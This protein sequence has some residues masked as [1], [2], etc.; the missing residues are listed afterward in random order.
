MTN[1]RQNF[2]PVL[3]KINDRKL[4]DLLMMGEQIEGS[5]LDFAY[6]IKVYSRNGRCVYQRLLEE[7]DFVDRDEDW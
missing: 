6:V 2:C 7:P 5:E 4:R 1:A 3:L